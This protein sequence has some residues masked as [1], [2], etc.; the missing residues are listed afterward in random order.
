MNLHAIFQL[1]SIVNLT[2]VVMG[3]EVTGG[4]KVCDIVVSRIRGTM[5][6]FHAQ[7]RNPSCRGKVRFRQGNLTYCLPLVDGKNDILQ[8]QVSFVLLFCSKYNVCH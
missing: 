2:F 6:K 7:E 1:L 4:G 3:Y 5:I 8:C